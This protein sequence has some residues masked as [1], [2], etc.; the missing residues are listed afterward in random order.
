[1]GVPC[2]YRSE[3]DGHDL[4]HEFLK[5]PLWEVHTSKYAIVKFMFDHINRRHNELVF[6]KC[7]CPECSY[8]TSHPVRAKEIFQFLE[9]KNMILFNLQQ[10][11]ANPGH[12][13]TFLE[14]C[15]LDPTITLADDSNMP[16]LQGSNLGKCTICP[17]YLLFVKKPKRR[18]T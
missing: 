17:A 15:E 18:G 8:G 2:V 12:Y 11:E 4:V 3:D 7:K 1:M 6:L 9:R 16:S 14:M 13:Y 10:S 5:A